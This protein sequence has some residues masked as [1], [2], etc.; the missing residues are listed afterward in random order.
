MRRAHTG[1]TTTHGARIGIKQLLPREIFNHCGT[2]TLERSLG[3]VGH[4]AH[5]TLWTI[6]VFEVHIQWR[7]KDVTQHGDWQKSQE[8]N[9]R[10]NVG[11]PHSLMPIL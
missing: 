10:H 8:G 6:T 1:A 2:K 9:E 3:E 4:C 7:S 5:C 11:D